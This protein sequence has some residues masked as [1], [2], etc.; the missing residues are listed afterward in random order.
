[1]VDGPLISAYK[2]KLVAE[3]SK[4]RLPTIYGARDAVEVGGLMSYGTS[5]RETFRRAASYVDQ[6]LKG[7]K[8]GDL[9]IEE[10]TKFELVVN[11][12][13]ARRLDLIIPESIL[14]R[15]DQI[16]R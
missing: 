1:V 13:T 6:I 12:N 3:A 14:V 8:A 5:F 7:A 10:P 9:P 15:A 16:I 4:A 11:L 2:H